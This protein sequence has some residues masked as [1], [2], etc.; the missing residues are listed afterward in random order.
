MAAAT[1]GSVGRGMVWM[2]VLSILLFWM[3]IAGPLIAGFVGGRRSGGVGNAILATILP[4]LLIG[5]AAFFLATLLTGVPLFGFM[6]GLGGAG[7]AL[8]HVGPMLVAA[9]VGAAL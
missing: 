9:I 3:P 7:L 5:A 6:A 2:L 1:T 4:G 8:A